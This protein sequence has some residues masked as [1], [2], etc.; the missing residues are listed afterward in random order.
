MKKRNT[1]TLIA[2]LFVAVLTGV[3]IFNTVAKYTTTVNNSGT[4]TVAKWNFQGDNTSASYDLNIAPTADTTTLV[5]GKIAPGTSGYFDIVVTNTSEVGANVTVALG[6]VTASGES[7]VVP[8]GLK[9]YTDENYTTEINAN[10][11]G[12]FTKNG[13]LT[14]KTG[15]TTPSLTLRVYWRWQYNVSGSADTADTTAGAA[16]ST[17]TIPVTITGTQ[18]EPSTSSISTAWAA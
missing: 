1:L 12:T 7:G 11:A 16:G 17:L 15:E 6:A 13:T 14:A 9:F 5:D 8:A 18:V 3:V 4:A 2:L 10:N